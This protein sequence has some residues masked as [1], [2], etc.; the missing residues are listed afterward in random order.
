MLD[1]HTSSKTSIL[2]LLSFLLFLYYLQRRDEFTRDYDLDVK[3]I[4]IQHSIFIRAIFI[5][6]IYFHFLFS[7]FWKW[8]Y[9]MNEWSPI[10]IWEVFKL[11]LFSGQNPFRWKCSAKKY[12]Y[13]D[14][15]SLLGKE[16]Y[17]H[18]YILFFLYIP[19]VLTF[20]IIVFYESVFL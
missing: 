20:L 17:F 6:V 9:P 10:D 11:I 3:A 13:I 14:S 15:E 4:R 5:F 19:D 12:I 18:A 8:Q 16:I 7:L 2:N 1:A